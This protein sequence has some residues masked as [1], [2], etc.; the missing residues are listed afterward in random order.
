MQVGVALFAKMAHQWRREAQRFGRTHGSGLVFFNPEIFDAVGAMC[1]CCRKN[2]L[3]E[4]CCFTAHGCHGCWWDI[5]LVVVSHWHALLLILLVSSHIIWIATRW[6][7]IIAS[8]LVLRA[9]AI[10]YGLAD[11]KLVWRITKL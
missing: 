3:A 7:L 4:S 2:Q 8:A 11:V 6:Q 9:L 1:L 5:G 10:T